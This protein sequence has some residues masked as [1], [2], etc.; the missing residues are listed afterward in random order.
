MFLMG[1]VW[2]E[3]VGGEER[4][5]ACQNYLYLKNALYQAYRHILTTVACVGFVLLFLMTTLNKM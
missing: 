4:S 3:G 1:R 2:G 5:M